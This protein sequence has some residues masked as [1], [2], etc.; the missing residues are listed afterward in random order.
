[1]IAVMPFEENPY[2]YLGDSFLGIFPRFTVIKLLGLIG[3]A[4][5]GVQ[6]LNGQAPLTIVD[7][8]QTRAFAAFLCAVAFGGV[9][10][11]A[12]LQPLTRL[13]AIVGLLPMVTVALRS[14]RDLR[15]VIIACAAIMVAVFPYALRQMHRF[16]GRL[17]VG[18][19]ETNYFALI[20]ALLLPLPLVLA[21]QNRGYKRLLWLIA[22]LVL[23]LELVLTGSR[24][25]FLALV[26]VVI[27]MA[28]RLSRSALP[29]LGGGV[30]VVLLVILAVPNPLRHR[31]LASGLSEDVYDSGIEAS[32]RQRL[33][34]VQGGLR[35]VASNPLTGVGLGNFKTELPRYV[36]VED[37]NIAHNT[38][39]ELAAELGLPALAAFL[40]VVV[41][42]LRSLDRSA[43][44]ARR[45][46][47][48]WLRDL[49][50]GMQAGL[51]GYLVG[52]FF[53]SA[54]YE[55]FFW[56]V[57]FLSIGVERIARRKARVARYAVE[58]GA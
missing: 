52:A 5:S 35:M 27:I 2:L 32:N 54:Q 36:D 7:S 51:S 53:L 8:A 17:G 16:G 41:A 56:L 24:G 26:C 46:G 3:L 23:L 19:Y 47:E 39:L 57:V 29:A 34:V 12:V 14:E 40:A 49:A 9:A 30:A 31:L 55:K 48:G 44:L 28:L 21:R 18:L 10:S 42:A 45:A 13:I 22:G 38:Y 58:A 20:L 11:G 33:A 6:F 43:R 15:R 1:M 25:G 50:L 4:W 37:S